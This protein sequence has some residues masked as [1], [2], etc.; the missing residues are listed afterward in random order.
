MILEAIH[1][2]FSEHE[3]VLADDWVNEEIPEDW[4]HNSAIVA[5]I[6]VQLKH[7]RRNADVDQDDRNDEANVSDISDRFCD[8]CDVKRRVVEKSQPIKYSF[9]SLTNNNESADVSL[10]NLDRFVKFK[11]VRDHDPKCSKVLEQVYPIIRRKKV[12]LFVL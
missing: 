5:R 2:E 8:Q 9:D 1:V 6:R 7:V 3:K 11:T 10:L 12:P 4:L